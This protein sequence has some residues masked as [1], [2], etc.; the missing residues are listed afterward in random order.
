MAS[1]WAA[2]SK[3]DVGEVRRLL[4]D[5]AVINQQSPFGFTALWFASCLG[6]PPVVKLLLERG[7]NP[8]IAE[9]RGSTPLMVATLKGRVEV[10]RVLIDHPSAR[11]TLNHRDREGRTALWWACQRG[12]G[13][14]AR[15]LLESGADLTIADNDGTTPMAL[16]KQQA[17][18]DRNDISAE[19]R[20]E[21]VAALEVRSC[22]PLLPPPSI[23]SSD[24]LAEKW[25]LLSWA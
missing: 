6:H 20:R 11:A 25:G 3:G 21:C 2:A 9:D 4:D 8:T 5:G 14:V 24:Q 22:L 18:P 12:R 1:I 15:A 10:V 16:A 13:G 7:A 19:G 23:C 17:P